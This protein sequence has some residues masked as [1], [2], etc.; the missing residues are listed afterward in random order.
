MVNV[1]PEVGPRQVDRD[2][3][4]PGGVG[5]V[6]GRLVVGSHWSQTNFLVGVRAFVIAQAPS[7]GGCASGRDQQPTA[8]DGSFQTDCAQGLEWHPHCHQ[9]AGYNVTSTDVPCLQIASDPLHLCHQSPVP[10]QDSIA[11]FLANNL[12]SLFVKNRRA[13]WL[14]AQAECFF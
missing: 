6:I 13:T 2:R 9:D 4:Q 1:R 11:R 14:L 7:C 8:V 10:N 3:S 5:S 12:C